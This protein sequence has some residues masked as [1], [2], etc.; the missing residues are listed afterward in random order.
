M[1]KLFV[2][3]LC[4]FAIL[5][6]GSS[7]NGAPNNTN[8]AE[9]N[10][11]VVAYYPEGVHAIPTDPVTYFSG[12]NLVTKRGNSSQIE[13]WYSN[14]ENHGFHSVWNIAKKN[15]CPD[16][17]VFFEQPY[18]EWGDYLNSSADYCVKVNSF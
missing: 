11:Q 1:Q 5:L 12:T 2:V 7:A 17:W 14:N 6:A 15:W 4:L 16:G 3:F 13:A 8:K 9:H 18:P 10:P